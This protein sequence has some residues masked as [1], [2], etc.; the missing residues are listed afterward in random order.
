MKVTT[1]I[2]RQCKRHTQDF[3]HTGLCDRCSDEPETR[4]DDERR[5]E[6]NQAN[7][8]LKKALE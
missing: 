4:D 5:R 1:I 6:E 7:R 2:C 3:D 8:E